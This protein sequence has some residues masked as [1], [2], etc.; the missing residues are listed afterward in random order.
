MLHNEGMAVGE[1]YLKQLKER[2]KKSHVYTEFQLLGLEI[3][4]IL[5]DRKH[6]ALYIKLAKNGNGRELLAIAKDVADRSTVKNKGA[7]FMAIVTDKKE[8][9]PKSE[10]YRSSPQPALKKKGPKKTVAPTA[11]KTKKK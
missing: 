2:E 3:A 4:D 8:E 6:K 9:K 7:Y 10:I 1:N 5:K 11:K